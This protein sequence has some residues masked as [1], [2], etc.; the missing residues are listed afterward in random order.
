MNDLTEK[1]RPST[2]IQAQIFD[3]ESSGWRRPVLGPP[4]LPVAQSSF[5]RPLTKAELMRRR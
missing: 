1:S 3:D 5:I 4:A 2:R